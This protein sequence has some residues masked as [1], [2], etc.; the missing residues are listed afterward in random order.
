MIRGMTD[1]TLTL[2]KT[3]IGGDTAPDDYEVI[4]QCRRI[5]RI[6]LA[7]ERSGHNPGWDWSITLPLPVPPW[8]R[9]S[10]ASFEAAKAAF[11]QAWA[12]FYATLTP[13]DIAHWHH[14]QDAAAK[15]ARS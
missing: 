10:E 15:Q 7:T 4:R 5:G 11:A 3:V 6:L 9:G 1:R 8:G 13:H 12:R 2:R 14:H